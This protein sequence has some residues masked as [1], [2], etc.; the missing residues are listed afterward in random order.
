MGDAAIDGIADAGLSFVADG[1]DGVEPS[2][3]GDVEEELG[4]VA[5]TENL[6]NGGEMSCPLFRIEVRS[7]DAAADALAP[8]ELASAAGPVSPGGHAAAVR[9]GS[10]AVS[11]SAGTS[12]HGGASQDIREREMRE[13]GLGLG[14]ARV[15]L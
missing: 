8:Q 13:R 15:L 3:S 4:S 2:V 5:C 9:A 10:T 7:E 11:C 6:V 1:D 14:A 12:A